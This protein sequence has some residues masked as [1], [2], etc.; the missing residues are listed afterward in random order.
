MGHGNNLYFL[1]SKSSGDVYHTFPS[2]LS[3][4]IPIKKWGVSRLRLVADQGC[5]ICPL[6]S[7]FQSKPQRDT[8]SREMLQEELEM[9]SIGNDLCWTKKECP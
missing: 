6:L 7:L 2:S 3:R 1:D 8:Q 4:P 9:G 5:V